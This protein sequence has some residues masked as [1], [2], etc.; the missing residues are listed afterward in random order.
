MDTVNS[1]IQSRMEETIAILAHSIMVDSGLK[2]QLGAGITLTGGMTHIEGTKE[3]AKA[4]IPNTPIRIGVPQY[5]QKASKDL[6]SVEY[7]TAIGL[8]LYEA[9][10]NTEYELERHKQMLHSKEYL[11][12][13][14]LGDLKTTFNGSSDSD[15]SSKASTKPSST[16][17]GEHLF[18][19][20]KEPERE[21]SNPMQSFVEWAKKIF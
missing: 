18:D 9:G 14:D 16:S 13:D 19:A 6:L 5:I 15:L 21:T 2:N 11:P 20:L 7:S 1:I 12:K 8:L 3:L 4:L 10:Y 17:T